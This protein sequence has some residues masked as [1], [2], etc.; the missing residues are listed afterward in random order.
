LVKWY[1][2]IVP[3]IRKLRQEDDKLKRLVGTSL[4]NIVRSH[5]KKRKEIKNKNS[6]YLLKFLIVLKFIYIKL[7]ILTIFC[8]F[9]FLAASGVELRAL[10]L[11]GRFQ[12]LHQPFFM[13]GIFNIASHKLFAWAGLEPRSS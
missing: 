8:L 12:P 11:L 3:T 10:C 5:L 2:P 6:K 13:F 9:L 4:T 1:A 7:A